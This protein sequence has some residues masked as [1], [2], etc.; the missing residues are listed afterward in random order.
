MSNT[1]DGPKEGF[2]PGESGAPK[3][4]HATLDLEATDVTPKDT[5]TSTAA[6]DADQA[7]MSDVD[8]G[9]TAAGARDRQREPAGFFVRFWTH[10]FAGAVGGLAAGLLAVKT[11]VPLW[12]EAGLS[13]ETQETVLALR[14]RVGALEQ[15]VKNASGAQDLAR[16][17]ADAEERL[18]KLD[19]MSSALGAL[20]ETE[21]RLEN[22]VKALDGRMA[23]Q[24]TADPAA[25]E[26]IGRLEDQLAALSAAAEAGGD[27][28][29]IQGLAAVTGKVAELEQGVASRLLA[30]RKDLSADIDP[31][32]AATAETAQRAQAGAERADRE[33]TGLKGES[34]RLG[35][36]LQTVETD[37]GRL[38]AALR[39]A[40]EARTRAAGAL[41]ALEGSLKS[42]L[43]AVARPEDI[44]AAVR[45]VGK[46]L[47]DLERAL[48]EV[49]KAETERKVGAA[50]IVMAL[51]LANLKRAVESGRSFSGEL[52][53][54]RDVSGGRVDLRALEPH[55][56]SGIPVLSDLA[57]DFKTVIRAALDAA[58]EPR[59][60]G[61]LERVLASAKSIVRVRKTQH[62]AGDKSAEAVLGRMEEALKGSRLAEVVELSKEL[63]AGSR[64]A[65]RDWLA[66]VEAREAAGRA[67]AAIETDLKS[68][69]GAGAPLETNAGASQPLE[70]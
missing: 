32:L 18:G 15:S 6:Q 69:L 49:V 47:A 46:K 25:A 67:I 7:M 29:R 11:G 30:L 2:Q 61:V 10:L 63:P 41:Q 26:R 22:E 52:A 62:E 12:P 9:T 35:E 17:L 66:K 59:S 42:E 50:R 5:E 64:E 23:G 70:N 20:S 31:R 19:E 13:G 57:R 24:P 21:A 39:S 56:D 28:G 43:G 4:P 37:I 60:G 38:D 36:R 45:P 65:A 55:K 3:R 14:Q 1:N 8:S 16:R 27:N 33:V 40:E 51:E 34:Q 53:S 68:S 44:A 58:E 48:A 54:V